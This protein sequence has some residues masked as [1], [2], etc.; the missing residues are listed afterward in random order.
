M[1]RNTSQAFT[2]ENLERL[3]DQV[4]NLQSQRRQLEV[5][6]ATLDGEVYLHNRD[7]ARV[8][9]PYT[10]DKHNELARELRQ[11]HQVENETE[12]EYQRVLSAYAIALTLHQAGRA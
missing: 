6:R 5:W 4:E 3:R 8:C 9:T 12:E 11:F 1:S 2:L 10:T 7:C